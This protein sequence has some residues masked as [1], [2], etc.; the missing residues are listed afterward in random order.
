MLVCFESIILSCFLMFGCCL[1]EFFPFLKGNGKEV[2]LGEKRWGWVAGRNGG[3]ANCG[4]NVL[5]ERRLFFFSTKNEEK[6]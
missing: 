4:Q 2:E 6:R 1:L 3:K 5:Y